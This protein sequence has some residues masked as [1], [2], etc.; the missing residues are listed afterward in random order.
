MIE[1]LITQA[2]ID[3]REPLKDRKF[4]AKL[5]GDKGYICKDLFEKLFVDNIHLITKIRKNLV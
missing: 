4:H 1:F 2:H 5:F 3:D